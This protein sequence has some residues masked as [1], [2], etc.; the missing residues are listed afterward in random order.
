MVNIQCLQWF[1]CEND[2]LSIQMTASD[3][4]LTNEAKKGKVI[5]Q[6]YTTKMLRKKLTLICVKCNAVSVRIIRLH[7]VHH[8]SSSGS[9]L[10]TSDLIA[11]LKD[12][13]FVVHILHPNL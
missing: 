4:F 12:G 5:L 3:T 6:V 11:R 2:H 7:N 1:F 9:F 13:S 10:H 8:K